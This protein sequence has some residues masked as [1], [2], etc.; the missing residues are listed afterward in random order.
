MPI[1]LVRSITEM[2]VIMPII[3]QETIRET[4]PVKQMATV[5]GWLL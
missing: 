2:W 3:I 1:F 5:W 4:A